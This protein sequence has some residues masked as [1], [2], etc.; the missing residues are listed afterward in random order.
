MTEWHKESERNKN[1]KI[2]KTQWE[3]Q[4]VKNNKKERRDS[5]AIVDQS[6]LA[7]VIV[8]GVTI[9]S[10]VAAS[11]P[12]TSRTPPLT[13]DFESTSSTVLPSLN[14]FKVLSITALTFSSPALP[15]D[16]KA[17]T[18]GGR[19]FLWDTLREIPEKP[20]LL[21]QNPQS[22][23]ISTSNHNKKAKFFHRKQPRLLKTE[24]TQKW[25]TKTTAFANSEK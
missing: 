13:A 17:N 22:I 15:L 11:S 16:P 2:I 1:I 6:D 8:Q 12:W 23:L 25:T 4:K 3:G 7:T 9:W 10:S 20:E 19:T 24:K 14:S 18:T 21:C 5:I